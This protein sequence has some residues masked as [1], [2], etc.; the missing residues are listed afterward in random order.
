MMNVRRFSP[1]LRSVLFL[2]LSVRL[3]VCQTGLSSRD[4]QELLSA[5][6]YFRGIVDPTA[7]NMEQM[8][9]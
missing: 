8:V 2:L 6:N 7:S 9:K 1:Y 5:H 4:E 3:S